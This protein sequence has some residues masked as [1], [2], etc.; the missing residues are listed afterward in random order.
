MRIA[1]F[2]LTLHYDAEYFYDGRL[3]GV[4]YEP[5]AYHSACAWEH[6]LFCEEHCKELVKIPLADADKY[7]CPMCEQSLSIP[8]FFGWDKRK[9]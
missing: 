5:T 2:L 6:D 1:G 7:I 3:S 8:V 9:Q 4:T